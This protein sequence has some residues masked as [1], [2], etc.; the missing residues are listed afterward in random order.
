MREVISSLSHLGAQQNSL[1]ACV[2]VQSETR[3]IPEWALHTAESAWF[4]QRC[5]GG[6]SVFHFAHTA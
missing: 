4:C 1:A 6:G 2:L 5:A 3:Y